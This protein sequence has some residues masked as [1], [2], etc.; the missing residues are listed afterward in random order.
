LDDAVTG[1]F[2]P[3]D[4]NW[5][6]NPKVIAV[7]LDGAG[8]H[9]TAMCVAKRLETDGVLHRSQ[10][11]R[12][13]A[14]AELID[15]LITERLFD[16]LGDGRI[17]VHGWLDRNPSQAAI[18]A[19]R[20]AKRVAAKRGNHERWGHTG[21]VETC[22][23]CNPPDPPPKSHSTPQEP[24][25]SQGATPPE[26]LN[27]SDTTPLGSPETE[28]ETETETN[29]PSSSSD[30]P[31][32][33]DEPAGG[34]QTRVV[35]RALDL[36]AERFVEHEQAQ[37]R[38]VDTP[39]GLAKWWLQE[40]ADGAR[41]RAERLLNDHDLTATQLAD[42]LASVNDP[43]WLR[44]YRRRTNGAKPAAHAAD[45]TLVKNVLAEARDA[46]EHPLRSEAS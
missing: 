19:D 7:G 4:V 45:E 38:R 1:L 23:T 46:I 41:Q 18:A 11:V 42:A 22:S 8:L 6:D 43:S 34:E 24:R 28:T 35:D 2:V 10:L 5:V 20:T 12:L 13:G 36:A 9:A 27:G 14:T 16:D 29:P 40:N 25:S 33:A 3:L 15:R 44:S 32:T 31:P 39:S 17:E 30:S 21:P 37:G 26:S